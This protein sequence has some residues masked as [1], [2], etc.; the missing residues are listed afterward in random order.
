MSTFLLFFFS[1]FIF[2]R[3]QVKVPNR[4]S[5]LKLLQVEGHPLTE[6]LALK[7]QSQIAQKWAKVQPNL[8]LISRYFTRKRKLGK[9]K[10]LNKQLF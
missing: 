8:E 3:N 6:L 4:D 10:H 9:H 7:M 2:L 1:Y 5:V